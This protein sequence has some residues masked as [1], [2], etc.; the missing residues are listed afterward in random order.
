VQTSDHLTVGTPD[1]NGAAANSVGSFRLDVRRS[2]NESA[3]IVR[4]AVSDVRCKPGVSACGNANATGGPDYTGELQ[5]DATIRITDHYNGPD[6]DET[7]TVVDIPFPVAMFCAS[8]A[9]TAV[10]ATC[11]STTTV[12]QPGI[13]NQDWYSGERVVVEITQVQVFDGGADGLNGTDGNTL[14]MNQGVFIP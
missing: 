2:A 1:A 9:D 13:P 7:A 12:V 14:F 6:H 5:S 4:A 11:E 8:T 3:L 10:G